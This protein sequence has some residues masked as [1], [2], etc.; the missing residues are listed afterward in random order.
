[1]IATG[2]LISVTET[3]TTNATNRSCLYCWRDQLSTVGISE[4]SAHSCQPGA[5]ATL[6][7]TNVLWFSNFSIDAS[8][9]LPVGWLYVSRVCVYLVGTVCF[10]IGGVVAGFG[11][12]VI[13]HLA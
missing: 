8:D 4:M 7:S 3:L 13:V 6:A 12:F 9:C 2:Q 5:L 1:M 10:R 11:R